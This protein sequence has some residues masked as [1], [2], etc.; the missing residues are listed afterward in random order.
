[1]SNV[2]EKWGELVAQR[3]FAQ[4]PNHLLLLNIFLDEQHKLSP[5]ELLILIQ[6]V[7][8]WW[9]TDDLPFPSMSTLANRCGVSSRQIQR[10]VNHLE[11]LGFI[12]R[13]KRRTKGIVASNAY[14]LEPLANVLNH[15][16][17]AFPNPYPRMVDKKAVKDVSGLL[18][19]AVPETE[20]ATP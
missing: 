18:K 4:V 9:R 14:D 3:G 16:A 13:V 5:T 19:P 2:S 20:A 10:S 6:L 8:T 7:G 1:V 12:Q 17:K 15:V 11:A